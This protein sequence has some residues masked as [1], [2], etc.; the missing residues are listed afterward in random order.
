MRIENT[1]EASDAYRCESCKGRRCAQFNTNSMG[2]V[3]LS[4]VPDMIVQCLD[5]NHT[6][7]V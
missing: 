3:H 1:A 7:T 4:A 6:F 2:A 5:C